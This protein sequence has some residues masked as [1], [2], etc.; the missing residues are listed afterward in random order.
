MEVFIYRS[1][2][3]CETFDLEDIKEL[4]EQLGSFSAVGPL[5]DTSEVKV[6]ITGT[7]GEIRELLSDSCFKDIW[8]DLER[9]PNAVE[10][11]CDVCGAGE[12]AHSDRLPKGWLA[13]KGG[14]AGGI[15]RC[16]KCGQPCTPENPCC[17]RRGEY[18][19][20]GS[21]GPLKFTC[22]KHC[23]CHD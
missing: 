6:E 21:D 8:F 1:P 15:I 4:E 20:F 3:G 2:T 17:D 13:K 7:W 11:Y 5:Q 16:Q 19:G 10:Y 9:S 22:P 14:S 12:W 18:N 23:C